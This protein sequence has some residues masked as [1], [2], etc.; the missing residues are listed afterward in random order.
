[1]SQSE[2]MFNGQRLTRAVLF[3]AGMGGAVLG[4]KACGQLTTQPFSES[5]ISMIVTGSPEMQ[6]KNAFIEEYMGLDSIK[7]SDIYFA[8]YNLATLASSAGSNSRVVLDRVNG[9]VIKYEAKYDSKFP[10]DTADVI[11]SR[12]IPDTD[13]SFNFYGT[14][15]VKSAASEDV[16][17]AYFLDEKR[18]VYMGIRDASKSKFFGQWNKFAGEERVEINVGDG[19]ELQIQVFSEG[20]DWAHLQRN[21]GVGAEKK[22][23]VVTDV[24]NRMELCQAEF[25]AGEPGS[26]NKCITDI[27]KLIS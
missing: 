1:M 22:E 10:V 4:A 19:N 5:H 6:L 7:D 21:Y 14:S 18:L 2:R 17:I 15:Y 16:P 20:L 27:N 23:S 26:I 12:S 13:I 9:Q 24:L 25:E 11:V 3:T 8:A